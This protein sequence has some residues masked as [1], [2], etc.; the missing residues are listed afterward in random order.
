V[1]GVSTFGYANSDAV[2]AT[3]TQPRHAHGEVKE[4]SGNIFIA[5]EWNYVIREVV[6][7]TG[8]VQTVIG[9]SAMDDNDTVN[10]HNIIRQCI[11]QASCYAAANPVSA[12]SKTS[13]PICH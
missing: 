3:G 8:K 6:N 7:A 5:D 1:A 2:S 4:A 12:E 13:K 11:Y 10:T 9:T